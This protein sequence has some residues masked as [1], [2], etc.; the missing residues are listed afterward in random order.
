MFSYDKGFV[1]RVKQYDN[2]SHLINAEDLAIWTVSYLDEDLGCL[3]RTE[4]LRYISQLAPISSKSL[5]W[6]ER[7]KSLDNAV[8]QTMTENVTKDVEIHMWLQREFVER[9]VKDQEFIETRM[10]LRFDQDASLQNNKTLVT[11]NNNTFEIDEDFEVQQDCFVPPKYIPYQ[12]DDMEEKSD[13]DSDSEELESMLVP[14]QFDTK[15]IVILD[16]DA[17]FFAQ[18][19]MND[20]KKNLCNELL[21]FTEDEISNFFGTQD[22]TLLTNSNLDPPLDDEQQVQSKINIDLKSLDKSIMERSIDG[23]DDFMCAMKGK[24]HDLWDKSTFDA[25]KN[26]IHVHRDGVLANFGSDTMNVINFHFSS[27]NWKE[28]QR[29]S[30]NE[31]KNIFFE[32]REPNPYAPKF[33]QI[34]FLND[35]K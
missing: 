32:N 27:Q 13:P 23:V 14:K 16:S 5:G 4:F 34:S 22:E 30:T 17:N 25:L 26:Y 9:F 12:N 33:G 7:D 10:E 6:E 18:V 21:Q 31:W 20:E 29:M 8:I 3:K 11:E 28:V 1:D 2:E 24:T 35:E 19:V 15:D